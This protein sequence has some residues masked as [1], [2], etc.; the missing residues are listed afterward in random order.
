[1]AAVK[2][3]ATVKW[4]KT[5]EP[6]DYGNTEIKWTICSTASNRDCTTTVE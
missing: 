4:T 5:I 2:A 1:M 3:C 6:Q